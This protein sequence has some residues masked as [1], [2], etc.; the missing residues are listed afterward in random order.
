MYLSRYIMGLPPT[1]EDKRVIDTIDQDPLNMQKSN[2][3]V[4]NR[5]IEGLN[6]K[7]SKNNK[8]GVTGISEKNNVYI[9]TIYHNK[10]IYRKLFSY[11]ENGI[12]KEKAF[13]LAVAWRIQKEE[14]FIKNMK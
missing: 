6:R 13:D 4:C 2:L 9:S 8:T 7:I 14:E 3:L 12:D 5:T 10:K 11:G 1:K